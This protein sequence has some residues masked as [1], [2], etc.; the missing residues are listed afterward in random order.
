MR[1]AR[2]LPPRCGRLPRMAALFGLVLTGWGCQQ[3]PTYF[4]YGYGAPPCT[5]VVPAPA[6]PVKGSSGQPSTEVIEGGTTSVTA[7]ARTT[8]VIGSDSSTRVVVSDPDDRP[9]SSWRRNPDSDNDAVA[10]SVEIEGGTSTSS[11]NSSTV[12]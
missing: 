6:T 7:P 12:R 9:R 3:P 4:Y 11:S 5:P 8:T 2:S 1:Q 10:S